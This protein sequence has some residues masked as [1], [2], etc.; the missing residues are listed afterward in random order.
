M[1]TKTSILPTF[2]PGSWREWLAAMALF[3]LLAL[4]SLLSYL[5][6]A[7][8]PWISWVLFGGPLL[9]LALG[10]IKGLPRWPL[11]YTGVIGLQLSWVFARR[12]TM[13]GINTRAG[14]VGSLLRWTDRLFFGVLR[15]SASDPWIVRAVYGAGE[16]WVVLL[17]MAAFAVLIATACRPLR[18]FYLRLR[19]DW[20]LLSFG[21]YGATVKAVHW[22]FEDYPHPHKQLYIFVAS[23]ILVAGAWVYL[24]SAHLW[25]RSLALFAA[26]TL[27]MAVAATGRAILYTNPLLWPPAAPR[28][29]TGRVRCYAR[30]SAGG[31]WWRWS[32]RRLY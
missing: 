10:L 18:P 15:P 29:F 27:S 6:I 12:G 31:G 22:A 2:E 4:T 11:P 21:L 25:Q 9:M 8:P 24:R 1:E 23:L 30:Y 20:T 14:V 28:S 26:I 5:H 17:G 7:W 13:M 32:W 19:D 3:L 16:L